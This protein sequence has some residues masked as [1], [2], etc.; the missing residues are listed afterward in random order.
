MP[1]WHILKVASALDNS[2]YLR[3]D[4]RKG[5]ITLHQRPLI[6]R[7]PSALVKRAG[8]Q[9][10]ARRLALGLTRAVVAER[11]GVSIETVRRFETTGQIA[12]ERLVRFAVALD[13]QPNV[14]ALFP[15]VPV[16]TLEDLERAETR[17]QRGVRR[18]AGVR[19]ARP[20]VGPDTP[21]SGA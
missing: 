6:N 2:L 7:T 14:D 16:E 1:Q 20:T 18:D 4:P 17:R 12:F 10:R 11:M 19:K 15:A 13:L 3:C 9:A 5:G 21:R 8:E